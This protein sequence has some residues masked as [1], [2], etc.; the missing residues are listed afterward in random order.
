M[1]TVVKPWQTTR[2][3]YYIYVIYFAAWVAVIFT[4]LNSFS[5]K[6]I[7]NNRDIH[8][9][10]SNKCPLAPLISG[11]PCKSSQHPHGG[12]TAHVYNQWFS[13]DL[14]TRII[15]IGVEK[16]LG[17]TSPEDVQSFKCI[18]NYLMILT[19]LILLTTAIIACL[20]SPPSPASLPKA[21][22]NRIFSKTVLWTYIKPFNR[23][24]C[25]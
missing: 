12:S 10:V 8:V 11:C 6:F 17:S 20:R 13:L 25:F 23:P 16:K 19:R 4:A 3:L 5:T 22:V 7:A 18:P 15:D 24:Q 1:P 21:R 14:I 9:N 2:L